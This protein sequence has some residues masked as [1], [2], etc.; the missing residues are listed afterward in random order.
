M[1]GRDVLFTLPLRGR[2]GAQRRGG[3]TFQGTQWITP[4]RSVAA[5]SPLKGE[6]KVVKIGQAHGGDV[7][8]TLPLRGRVG[9]QRRGG[10]TFH[11]TQWITPT[12]SVAA[13]SPL[14]GEV[15][16]VKIGQAH[17]GDVPSTLPLRGRVGA[18]RRGGVTFPGTQ[19]VTPTRSVAATSPLKGEV[20]AIERGQ[21]HG[22]DAP[23]TLPS[24]G[25]V[26]GQRRGGVT[27]HR[28]QWITPTRS[29]AATSPL[30]GEVK[31]VKIGQ[32]HGGDVPSTLPLRGRVGAQRR[33]GVTFPGTQPV[34]PTRSVA[35]TS[36]LKGEVK[37]DREGYSTQ[38]AS[39]P[40][41][42]FPQQSR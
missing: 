27:F 30:K 15:K 17:G 11:R 13:T 26:G 20:K 12:R 23:S 39:H 38:N 1:Q 16:V 25:R 35:A 33:G 40:V 2:V 10:V 3:V 32:A 28:T 31:V 36:P 7:P 29:V 19:P 9:A 24:R 4:T 41:P 18:Q 21:S 22:G 34:T 42:F 14:K 37:K 5:T 6:V 8:S